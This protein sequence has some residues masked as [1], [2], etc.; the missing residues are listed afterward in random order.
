MVVL[1]LLHFGVVVLD[2]SV[3]FLDLFPRVVVEVVDHVFLD[4][5]HVPLDLGFFKLFFQVRLNRLQL[6]D[7]HGHVLILGLLL[8]FLSF[9]LLA[10]LLLASHLIN[11]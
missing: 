9:S 6:F 5:K 11:Y 2:L 1:C 10:S 3:Q 4:L 8:G 7:P